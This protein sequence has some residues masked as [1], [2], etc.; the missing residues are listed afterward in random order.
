MS[1]P[2][3][4]RYK[5]DRGCSI[6]STLPHREE[7]L[8][9][10]RSVS[11]AGAE[12]AWL[13]PSE[14][15]GRQHLTV[16][17]WVPAPNGKYIAY[18]AHAEGADEAILHVRNVL[19]R[20]DESQDN[21]PGANFADVAW[22]P[23]SQGFYYMKLPMG[24]AIPD[25]ERG[26]ANGDIRYHSI[27]HNPS[28][29]VLIYPPTGDASKYLTPQA[30]VDGHW[31]FVT[32]AHGWTDN[33][34]YYS[35]REGSSFH[36]KTLFFSTSAVSDAAAWKDHFYLHTNESAPHGKVLRKK[37]QDA[38]WKTIIPERADVTIESMHVVGG[39]IVLSVLKNV[40]N[41]LEVYGSLMAIKS[42]KF[43]SRIME[44]C[45]T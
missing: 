25:S 43:R 30:S 17:A 26:V 37:P 34:I 6:S 16:G 39:Y 38:I 13:D 1:I 20:Q 7:P 41:A 8:F 31:I 24:T 35:S 3:R 22:S 12:Q 19:S 18:S 11:H 21:I 9:L 5:R 29:D 45:G 23:D 33:A 4:S 28:Q 36:F 10:S 44:W 27:G 15:G 42:G 14:L 32:V 2:C 40:S